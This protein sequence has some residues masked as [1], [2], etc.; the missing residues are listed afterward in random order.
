MA[1]GQRVRLGVRCKISR[2]RV[3]DCRNKRSPDVIS[4]ELTGVMGDSVRVRTD[5]AELVI[6]KSAVAQAWT[7][8]GKRGQV[9]EGAAIGLVGGVLLGAVVGA[10]T[11]SCMLDCGPSTEFGAIGGA[12]VGVVLGGI[13]GSQIHTDRW[14]EIDPVRLSVTPRGRGVGLGMSLAF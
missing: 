1:Q 11:E 12:V 6:P 3:S 4:G 5:R 9:V 10:G 2:E 13:I 7:V 8:D 14:R